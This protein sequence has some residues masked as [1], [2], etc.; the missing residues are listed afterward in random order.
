M[1]IATDANMPEHC[2]AFDSVLKDA[3]TPQAHA[4]DQNTWAAA[5]S[6]TWTIV[7]PPV[8]KPTDLK[9][10]SQTQYLAQQR[11]TEAAHSRTWSTNDARINPL[12]LPKRKGEFV[13]LCYRFDNLDFAVT[14]IG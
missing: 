11:S 10:E 8:R 1:R 12:N 3:L 13:F 2:A 5:Y 14:W 7:N 4:R 9:P 6:P